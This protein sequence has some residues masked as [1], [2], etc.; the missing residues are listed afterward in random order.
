MYD[1]ARFIAEDCDAGLNCAEL[2]WRIT[3][4]DEAMRAT[5]AL[6]WAVKSKMMLFAASPLFNA[7]EDH[8]EEAYQMNK[9]AVEELKKEWVCIIYHMY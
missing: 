5:K 2:P 3:T 1:V 9:Q 7:G 4:E 6:A 8:W